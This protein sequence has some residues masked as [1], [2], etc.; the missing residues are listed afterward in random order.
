MKKT[1]LDKIGFFG[2]QI[3]F[4][5]NVYKLFY[6]KVFLFAYI[7]FFFVNSLSNKVLKECIREPRPKNQ[8]L[9]EEYQD[10]STIEKY[11]MPSGHAQSSCFSLTFLFLT[12][13][14]L[15]V[16]FGL[17]I[18]VLTLY[19]RYKHNR[20]TLTQLFVGSL[21]GIFFSCCVFYSTKYYLDSQTDKNVTLI[22]NVSN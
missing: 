22:Y 14:T 2:P 20:H 10:F 4:F 17:C 7:I 18:V 9:M 19:Q 21:I 6:R 13:Q 3:L 1:I 11:G 8:I 15:W 5:L 12:T 16:L